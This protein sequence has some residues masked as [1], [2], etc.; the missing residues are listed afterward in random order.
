MAAE[1]QGTVDTSAF[2]TNPTIATSGPSLMIGGVPN[3]SLIAKY[4]SSRP[5]RDTLW[6]PLRPRA[7][8]ITHYTHIIAPRHLSA[9]QHSA[10]ATPSIT[11]A[12]CCG[13]TIP[14][15][16]PE[17]VSALQDYPDQTFAAYISEGINKGGARSATSTTRTSTSPSTSTPPQ[18][19][20]T[21]AQFETTWLPSS[22]QGE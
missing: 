8:H 17:W 11:S 20:P 4:P 16:H 9:L 14:L 5:L 2:V 12:C 6:S 21:R 1:G 19:T 10:P 18:H 3:T 13:I 22:V 15:V 7:D